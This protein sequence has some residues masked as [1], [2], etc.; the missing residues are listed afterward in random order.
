MSAFKDGQPEEF[1]TLHKNFRMAIDGIRTTSLSVRIDYLR[2][3]LRGES[4]IY[5]DEL[6]SQ[7]NCMS[8]THK[9]HIM[10][11][12]LGYVPQPIHY[13]SKSAMC[14]TMLKPRSILFKRFTARLTE[15]NI[16]SPILPGL[17]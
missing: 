11:G 2:K 8:S 7:N 17:I 13:L 10:E 9:N 1:L 16:N 15:I 5:F 14:R 4:L 6:S 3:M 12:L